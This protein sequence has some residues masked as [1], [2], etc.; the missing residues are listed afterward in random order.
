MELNWFQGI[1]PL[2]EDGL[3]SYLNNTVGDVIAYISPIFTSMLIIWIAIWGYMLMLGKS[4][5]PLQEGLF[6]IIRIGFIMTLGLSTATYMDVVVDFLAN[7]PTEIAG[8]VTGSPAESPAAILDNLL[9]KVFSIGND[10]W[11][12]AGVMNGNF[13][14]Y[15]VGLLVMIAGTLLT[16]GITILLLG[17]KICLT[18]ALA[19]GPIFIVFLLFNATQRF[20]ENWLQQT[21]N[22]G[23]IIIL[24]SALGRLIV[25]MS[26]FI[27]SK[28][29]A[30]TDM[31]EVWAAVMLFGLFF[32]FGK[33]L[34]LI[35]SVASALSGGVAMGMQGALGAT[36][37]AMRPSTIRRQYQGVKR[38]AR[39][40]GNA[41]TS[42]YRGAKK[43]YAAY[44]KRF[45]AGNTITGG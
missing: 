20:F 30:S 31:T 2:I 32:M 39:L 33:I 1:F 35:P 24:S 10:T 11:D 3:I 38:D 29:E 6:R 36:M 13:G 44:Q 15:L 5:E 26:E 23:M 4:S 16:F 37:N 12:K 8:V 34:N 41:A 9:L 43:A 40:V 7:G 19:L 27:I 28:M 22:F 18:I 45:G 25:E 17:G 42:P 14:F 21:I